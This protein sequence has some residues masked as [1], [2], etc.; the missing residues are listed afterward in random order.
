[1]NILKTLKER[2][3]LKTSLISIQDTGI[4]QILLDMLIL[5]QKKTDEFVFRDIKCLICCFIH[6]MF[7][8][9][10]NLA[11]LVHFQVIKSFDY[12]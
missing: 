7:I 11:E 3:E 2:Q 1:M 12:K 6:Q 4:I 8:E 9:N 10:T 5:L